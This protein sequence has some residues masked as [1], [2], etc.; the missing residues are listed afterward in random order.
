MA[1]EGAYVVTNLRVNGCPAW[2]VSKACFPN[3]AV[4]DPAQRG[5]AGFGRA[6]L[7]HFGSIS[8]AIQRKRNRSQRPP[9][10]VLEEGKSLGAIDLQPDY[11]SKR[12]GD[13][14]PSWP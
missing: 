2:I 6:S 11:S 13:S 8:A 5:G 1:S 10:K 4:E 14:E 3:C 9:P 12:K 7:A